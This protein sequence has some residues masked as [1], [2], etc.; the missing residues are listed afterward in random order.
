MNEALV[1]IPGAGRPIALLRMFLGTSDPSG[2]SLRM[3]YRDLASADC[4]PIVFVPWE[5]RQCVMSPIIAW[6]KW[7]TSF[8]FIELTDHSLFLRAYRAL[9]NVA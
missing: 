3:L 8:H 4:C 9:S 6:T 2:R 5:P 7:F 1:D